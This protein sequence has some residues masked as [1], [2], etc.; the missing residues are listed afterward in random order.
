MDLL[1]L[2]ILAPRVSTGPVR[3]GDH[4]P[5]EDLAGLPGWRKTWAPLAAALVVGA[6][7]L[8]RIDDVFYFLYGHEAQGLLLATAIADGHGFVDLSLPGHPAHVREPPLFYLTLAGLIRL[9]GFKLLPLKIF[10]GAS[11]A[12]AAGLATAFFQRRFSP[13]LSFLAA[14]IGL[15]GPVLFNFL[16]GPKSELPFTALMFAALLLL[17]SFIAR[18]CRRVDGDRLQV[19]LLGLAAGTM[20]LL[21]VM[22]RTL[23][24]ALLLAGIGALMVSGRRRL[25]L[26]PRLLGS[27]VLAAPTMIGYLG[28]TLRNRRVPNPAGYSYLDWFRMDLAPDSPA[29][30]AVDFHAPLMGPVPH[31]SAGA[32]LLRAGRHAVNYVAYL[33]GSVHNLDWLNFAGGGEIITGL[34]SAAYLLLAALALRVLVPLEKSKAGAPLAPMFMAGYLAAV[35]LWPMDDPRLMLP[36]MPLAAYYILLG[37]YGLAR[38]AIVA[39]DPPLPERPI[40][41]AL[42]AAGLLLLGSNIA[43]DAAAQRAYS[44]LPTVEFRPGFRVRFMSREGYDSFNLLLWA[45]R[46]T[47]PGA[48][49]MY[50]SP[51]PC[52][53]ISGHDCSPI[54]M[55]DDLAAVRDFIT[56]GGAD[57][58]IV[59][60]WGRGFPGGAGWFTEHVLRP[61]AEKYPD[62]F[63]TVE[64]VPGREAYVLRVKK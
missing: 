1:R 12:A 37:G 23:G 41:A 43:R 36:L 18:Y 60:E 57:Y 8:L 55:S 63:E 20:V 44:K 26:W 10:I 13:L 46:H 22:T 35:L 16:S 27:V 38:A 45:G 14:A 32:M 47:P 49:L 58:L 50:H 51:P 34:K 31:A 25:R 4:E 28:W 59:D 30:T 54:P 7:C 39:R 3:W 6:V 15:T 19:H 56:G 53:L 5:G 9:F 42:L 33:G 21:A 11:Y 17:E 29:M 62:R 52:R 48:V 24:M 64:R 40:K 2:S 61:A